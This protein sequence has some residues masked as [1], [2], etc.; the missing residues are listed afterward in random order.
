MTLEADNIVFDMLL[1]RKGEYHV[2]FYMAPS[3]YK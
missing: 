2:Y 3:L 1:G